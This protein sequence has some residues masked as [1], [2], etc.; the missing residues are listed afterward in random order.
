M[1]GRGALYIHGGILGHFFKEQPG[2]RAGALSGEAQGRTGA[3]EKASGE[4]PG[5]FKT[6]S[7]RPEKD[8]DE[9]SDVDG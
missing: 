8:R 5:A 9:V 2:R 7:R 1:T 3:S 4:T 6:D